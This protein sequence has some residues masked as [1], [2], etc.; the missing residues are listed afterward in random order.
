M[1]GLHKV[2]FI[3]PSG[4]A[5][6]D[7]DL[8]RTVVDPP[9]KIEKSCWVYSLSTRQALETFGRVDVRG[10][11]VYHLGEVLEDATEL[12]LESGEVLT[13]EARRQVVGKATYRARGRAGRGHQD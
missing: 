9:Q 13:I 6:Y 3:V 5:Y 1:V 8:G 7:P 2:L 11:E 4:A 10:I 12:E